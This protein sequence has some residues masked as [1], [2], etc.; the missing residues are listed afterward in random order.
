EGDRVRRFDRTLPSATLIACT[1]LAVVAS[2]CSSGSGGKPRSTATTK[3]S[4]A[5]STTSAP[6]RPAGPAADLSQEI[7]GGNGPFIGEA[8]PP[9]LKKVGYVQHE[10]VASGTATAYKAKSRFSRD[11]RWSFEPDTKAAYRTR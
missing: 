5:T 4:P 7:T 1:V 3:P 9:N 10:Y 6:V 8:A 2:A 11:G